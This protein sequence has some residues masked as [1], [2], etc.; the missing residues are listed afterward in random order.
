MAVRIEDM[1]D[2]G[3][4]WDA[5]NGVKFTVTAI[6]TKESGTWITYIKEENG[7]EYNCLVE[8]FLARFRESPK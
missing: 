2:L 3:S 4:V 8:A 7:S 1:V 5:G 6:E